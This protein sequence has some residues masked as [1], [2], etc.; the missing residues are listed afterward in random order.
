MRNFRH[1]D[2]NLYDFP[3]Q[4]IKQCDYKSAHTENDALLEIK[5]DVVEK[6]LR[7]RK[8]GLK[9]CVVREG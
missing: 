7:E 9:R 6:A 5:K 8:N 1:N 4:S 2:E 3:T